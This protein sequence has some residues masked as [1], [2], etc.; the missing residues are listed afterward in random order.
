MGRRKNIKRR[1]IIIKDSIVKIDCHY[2]EYACCLDNMSAV[3]CYVDDFA[4]FDHHVIDSQKEAEEC[5]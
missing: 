5:C 3:D 1:R 4:Y 2:C